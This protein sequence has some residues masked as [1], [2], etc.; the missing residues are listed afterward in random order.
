MNVALRFVSEQN[1]ITILIAMSEFIVIENFL[2][3]MH[4]AVCQSF[5]NCCKGV[6]VTVLVS[7]CGGR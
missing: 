3:T 6:A 7:I 5:C 4:H 1:S 2:H